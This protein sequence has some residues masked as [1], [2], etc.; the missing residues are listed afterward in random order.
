M[1]MVVARVEP[2]STSSSLAVMSRVNTIVD[3]EAAAMLTKLLPIR[4]VEK[5]SSGF[6]NIFFNKIAFLFFLLALRLSLTLFR[7]SREVSAEEKK[8]LKKIERI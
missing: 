5:N 6:F 1:I 8:A 4:M 3:M 7:D 2:N